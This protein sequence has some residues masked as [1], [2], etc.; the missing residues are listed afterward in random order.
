M[1]AM[2]KL[3][4]ALLTLVMVLGMTVPALA[5]E[6]TGQKGSI[7]INNAVEDQEYHLYKI[8]DLT[9]YK[10]A[11]DTEEAAYTYKVNAAW[12]GFINQNTIKDV[13][14]KVDTNGYVSWVENAD[15]AQFAK[16]ALEWAEK[17][18]IQTVKTVSSKTT[19]DTAV[20]VT[21]N[22]GAKAGT[23]TI[24]ISELDLGY[25]L[26]DSNVG[27]ICSLDTNIP[28]VEIN[29]KNGE[30]TID[31][32]VNAGTTDQPV[33][34]DENTAQIGDTVEFKV[35]VTA[36][37]GA[38]RY[39]LH[40]K[41]QKG[42]TF[43]SDSVKV[44]YKNAKLTNEYTINDS[45]TDD[46]TFEVIFNQ[47]FCDTLTAGEKITVTYSATL[48]KDAVIGETGNENEVKL[49]YGQDSSI[50]T[51]PDK[52]ITRTYQFQIIKTN[53][54]TQGNK[55]DILTG[56]EFALYDQETGG[57]AIEF[58]QVS[59]GV[60]CVATDED[61]AAKITEI[62]AGTPVLQ[63]LD[64]KKYWLEEVK[65][66]DGYRPM[67]GRE[68]VNLTNDNLAGENAIDQD[69]FTYDKS[70]GGGIQ[71]MNEKGNKLPNTGGMGTT[72]FYTIG[73]VLV[74]CAAAAMIAVL[75]KGK[76]A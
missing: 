44:E 70:I 48:N 75:R 68:S 58:V 37:T 55:Y 1:K 23:Y 21:A 14:V 56:A 43:N 2:K 52:T 50:E 34:T 13:Y 45:T 5:A 40:E 60:Y 26:L 29:D 47:D 42:L 24:K 15:A 39:I 12:T 59:E 9:S 16:L 66:P 64:A 22:T 6:T 20:I 28:D 57:N 32:T 4:T 49:S 8:F 7:T 53:K 3:L 33:W 36:Q 11:S 54:E 76:K 62:P 71:V 38:Q 31:K 10:E 30:P 72:L 67:E 63:G 41:M 69:K 46:C 19:G 25:Y 18:N 61:T 17:N 65:A 35:E 73:G 74:I 51:L 27:T